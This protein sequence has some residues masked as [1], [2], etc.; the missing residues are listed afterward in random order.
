MIMKLRHI[1]RPRSAWANE[2]TKVKMETAMDNKKR[3][4]RDTVSEGS[5]AA[6]AND[7]RVGE[8]ELTEASAVPRDKKPRREGGLWEEGDDML[9]LLAKMRVE[10]LAPSQ[11]GTILSSLSPLCVERG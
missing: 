10:E 11:K 5:T 2:K 6:A 4:E 3:K 8:G 1:C 9:L 7:T